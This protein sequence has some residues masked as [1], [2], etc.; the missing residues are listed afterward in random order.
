MSSRGF[1]LIEIMIAMVIG[2]VVIG[3][4]SAMFYSIHRSYMV[5]LAMSRVEDEGYFAVQYMNDLIRMAGYRHAMAP[6]P[7]GLEFDGSN[8]IIIR[9]DANFDC[10]GQKSDQYDAYEYQFSLLR[11]DKSLQR[12]CDNITTG[13]TSQE[14]IAGSGSSDS[15]YGAQ[16]EDLQFRIGI[17]RDGDG[18]VDRYD[19]PTAIG[20]TNPEEALQ[21]R[22]VQLCLE[23]SSSNPAFRG[24][25]ISKPYVPCS[26]WSAGD[27]TQSVPNYC[28]DRYCQVFLSTIYLR[29]RSMP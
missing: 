21:V 18:Y 10:D 26:V 7:L 12:A 27:A 23:I 1:T 6:D 24:Q 11:E 8:L 16:V 25:N 20:W 13:A 2:L 3:G 28:N 9:L 19:Q 4:A 22:S 29:N 14:P 17:D 5:Q 15:L